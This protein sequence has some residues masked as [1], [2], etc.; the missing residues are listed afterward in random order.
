MKLAGS[1]TVFQVFFIP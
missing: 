1:T